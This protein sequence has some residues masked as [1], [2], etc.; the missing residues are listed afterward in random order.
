MKDGFTTF[1][2]A[3]AKETPANAPAPIKEV[4]P[5]AFVAKPAPTESGHK[6][7]DAP[8]PAGTRADIIMEITRIVEAGVTPQAFD[9][10]LD[11][12]GITGQWDKAT[13]E[14]LRKLRDALQPVKAQWGE[15][16][17]PFELG[18]K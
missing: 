16:D 4:D 6:A 9:A 17:A 10:A 14:Q 11:T 1:E 18:G 15:D 13:A 12:V 8:K 3:F 7:D 5:T 2:E